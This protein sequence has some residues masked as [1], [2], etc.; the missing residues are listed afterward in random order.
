MLLVEAG[1]AAPAPPWWSLVGGLDP[2]TSTGEQF[3]TPA[4][5][6]L[7]LRR[8]VGLGG[9][10][11]VN[12]TYFVHAPGADQHLW[13]ELGGDRWSPE[14]I[15]GARRRSESDLDRPEDPVHGHQGPIPVQRDATLEPVSEAF[16]AACLAQGHSW[17]LDLNGAEPFGVGLVP[18]AR[19]G[20]RRVTPA[21]AYLEPLE[22]HGAFTVRT[23]VR[24]LRLV[25]KGSVVEGAELRHDS[26]SQVVRANLTVLCA[27]AWG[28]AELLLRSG[29]GPADALRR[30]GIDVVA[31]LPVGAAASNHLCVELPFVPRAAARGTAPA[32]FMQTALHAELPATSSG[33]AEA[34]STVVEVLATRRPY[35]VVTGADPDDDRL[36]LRLTLMTPSARIE[37]RPGADAGAPLRAG[38]PDADRAAWHQD[39]AALA[40]SV[41]RVSRLAAGP[42]LRSV[43]DVWHGPDQDVLGDE[44]ALQT[45]VRAHL[46]VA[47][48]LC[49]TAPMGSSGRAG[50]VVDGELRVLGMQGVVV[51]DTSVLPVVPARGPAATAV[52]VGELAAEW[53]AQD[54]SP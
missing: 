43:I 46:G 33:G 4:G 50:S 38:V 15:G 23:D 37:L 24:A 10:G 12:G 19:R 9:S 14:R 34:R 6:S 41:R 54:G 18:F 40:E 32:S 36:S 47:H 2:A 31:D 20:P 53:L 25:S 16:V 42:E 48:H 11:A 1:G 26:G 13:H 52:L 45:W 8:G 22:G 30:T 3:S 7:E 17:N 28:S 44:T 49:S 29:I 27:G 5:G 39:L 35:G 51:A 21:Q